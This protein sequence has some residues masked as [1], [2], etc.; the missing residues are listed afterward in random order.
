MISR[1]GVRVT[2]FDQNDWVKTF[3][4]NRQNVADNLVLFRALRKSNLALFK[5]VPKKKLKSSYG[6]HEERGKETVPFFI[7][8]TAGHDLNHLMQ[9]QRILK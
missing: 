2:A 9:L 5:L 8:L 7:K 3:Q 6:M 4:Y 1:P